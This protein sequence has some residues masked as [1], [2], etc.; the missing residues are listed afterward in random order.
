MSDVSISAVHSL[1]SII[2]LL[3]FSFA[4]HIIVE[5]LFISRPFLENDM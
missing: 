4:V 5:A 1:F 3:Y 2:L